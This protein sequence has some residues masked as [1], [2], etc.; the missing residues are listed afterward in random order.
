MK[1]PLIIKFS[2]SVVV[3]TA[4]LLAHDSQG[5]ISITGGGLSYSQDF[6]TLTRSTTAENWTDNTATT[7]LNDNPQLV[8]L[9]GW[10]AA[11]FTSASAT[12]IN[13][14]YTP[15]IR[16]GTGSSSTGSFYSFGANADSDRALGTLPSDSITANGA[17][18]LRL[19]VRFV[20][21]TGLTITGFTFSYD[22]EQWRAGA[23]TP[24][25]VNNQFAFSYAVFGPG[26]GTLANSTYIVDPTGNFNTPDDGVGDGSSHTLDGNAPAN[27]IAGIGDTI[28]GLSVAPG[29]EI[30]LRWSDA[31]SSSADMG[32]GIDNFSITFAVP[33]PSSAILLGLGL[34]CFL[35]H[36]RRRI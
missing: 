21:D 32:I 22:G 30:W 24:A 20:N 3:I 1:N 16:A 12:V 19:G 7:S 26:L 28:T 4:L 36:A 15:Q 18:A 34:V 29:D 13:P 8:G 9:V 11:S 23:V 6:D 35:N 2:P 31:N 33:E 27:R 10:Y 17:G 14:G 5:Q 25:P